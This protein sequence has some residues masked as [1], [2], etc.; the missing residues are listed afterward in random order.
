[1]LEK[2]AVSSD[3]AFFLYDEALAKPH[4][5]TA[6]VAPGPPIIVPLPA[7]EGVVPCLRLPVAFATQTGAARTGRH[8]RR[9]VLQDAQTKYNR[10]PCAPPFVSTGFGLLEILPGLSLLAP[11]HTHIPGLLPLPALEVS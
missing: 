6:G 11:S 5:E 8:P 4:A 3:T 10:N 2:R 9:R 7:R 1:M